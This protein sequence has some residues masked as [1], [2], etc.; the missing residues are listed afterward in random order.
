MPSGTR[1]RMDT[2][3][4]EGGMKMIREL[5]ARLR[6]AIKE[7]QRNEWERSGRVP[8]VNVSDYGYRLEIQFTDEEHDDLY[9][10]NEEE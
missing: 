2:T 3:T 9:T 1:G 10:K 8:D 6:A 4:K 7:W 5:K